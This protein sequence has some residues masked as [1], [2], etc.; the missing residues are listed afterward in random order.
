MEETKPS[1]WRRTRAL[2]RKAEHTWPFWA[3]VAGSMAVCAGIGLLL[4]FS[5]GLIAVGVASFGFGV[6]NEEDE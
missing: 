4:G 3:Q 6:V 5:A 2:L 1:R